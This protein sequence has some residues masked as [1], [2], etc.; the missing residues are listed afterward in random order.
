MPEWSRVYV[1]L[2]GDSAVDLIRADFSRQPEA[3]RRFVDVFLAAHHQRLLAE[4]D[5]ATT[6]TADQA[7]AFAVRL[8]PA[9]PRSYSA[10]HEPHRPSPRVR[11]D[12]W[13]ETCSDAPRRSRLS[14]PGV[15]G[16][17]SG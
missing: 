13:V 1:T 5:P 4:E 11:I 9:R 3:M 10:V 6:F 7:R 14:Y 15:G 2:G 17:C 12:R 16:K 8:L